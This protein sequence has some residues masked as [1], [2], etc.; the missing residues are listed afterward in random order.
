[1]SVALAISSTTFAIET[2]TA[3]TVD[4]KAKLTKTVPTTAAEKSLSFSFLTQTKIVYVASATGPNSRYDKYSAIYSHPANKQTQKG[5]LK[6]T[7]RL[8]TP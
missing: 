5:N 3:N 2:K 7:R 4:K 6:C 1:M 8:S